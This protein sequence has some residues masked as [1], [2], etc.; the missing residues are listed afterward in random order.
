MIISRVKFKSYFKRKSVKESFLIEVYNHFNVN[1]QDSLFP[2]S[3][4]VNN[5]TT[6]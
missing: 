6:K 1:M 3:V 5:F 4:L 2:S